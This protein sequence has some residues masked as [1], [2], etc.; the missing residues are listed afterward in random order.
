MRVQVYSP[1]GVQLITA[2]A[3]PLEFLP[4]HTRAR[5]SVVV[6]GFD[7]TAPGRLQFGIETREKGKW[8][9]VHRVPFDIDAVAAIK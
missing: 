7:I 9:E 2:E 6:A 5:M 1:D 4:E 8:V 3:D